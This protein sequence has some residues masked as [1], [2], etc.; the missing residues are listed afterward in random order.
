MKG[1]ASRGM[2]GILPMAMSGKNPLKSPMSAIGMVS[3][4]AGMLMGSGS[5]TSAGAQANKA[6]KMKAKNQRLKATIASGG[7]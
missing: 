6:D 7:Y 3:P 1:L 5:K 4:L 2:G